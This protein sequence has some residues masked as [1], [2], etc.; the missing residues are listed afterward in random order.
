MSEEA[1]LQDLLCA[2]FV[3]PVYQSDLGGMV[4]EVKSLLDRGIAAADD[5]DLLSAVEEAVANRTGR[6]AATRI[7][8]LSRTAEPFRLGA[9]T[10]TGF[11]FARA[12]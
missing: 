4:R 5:D 8:R 10:R 3:P 11:R 6:N 12:A 9:V 2:Q 7:L 1:I